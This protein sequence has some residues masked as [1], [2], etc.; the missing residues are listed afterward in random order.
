MIVV[1]A[2]VCFISMELNC[3]VCVGYRVSLLS[4][5]A[6]LYILQPLPVVSCSQHHARSCWKP[7]DHY[8]H[9]PPIYN[10]AARTLHFPFLPTDNS[11]WMTIRPVS[12]ILFSV[13]PDR[14][15]SRNHHYNTK[16]DES[17]QLVRIPAII[18]HAYPQQM[19]PIAAKTNNITSVTR[20]SANVQFPHPLQGPVR[21][22]I[23]R[24]TC[25]DS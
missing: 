8:C 21:C 19:L 22:S 4:K 16:S 7:K 24:D 9:L 5:G 14:M 2:L 13:A 23:D 11:D 17:N 3:L 18:V 1:L 10:T 12:G 6:T 20:N 25:L 15:N